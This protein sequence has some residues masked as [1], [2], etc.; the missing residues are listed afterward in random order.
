[1]LI[2]I[3]FYHIYNIKNTDREDIYYSRE[4]LTFHHNDI[5]FINYFPCNFCQF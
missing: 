1:M 3:K 2:K 4:L 5:Q